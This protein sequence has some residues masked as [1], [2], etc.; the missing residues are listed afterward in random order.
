[1]K[2][3]KLFVVASMLTAF[4]SQAMAQTGERNPTLSPEETKSCYVF[5]ANQSSTF[6]QLTKHA[7]FVSVDAAKM[8]DLADDEKKFVAVWTR[9]NATKKPLPVSLCGMF[10]H[11]AED[12]NK[13]THDLVAKHSQIKSSKESL[14]ADGKKRATDNNKKTSSPVKK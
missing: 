5:L 12:I 14:N 2:Q 11:H 3:V 13:E 7:S 9:A 1:M 6:I 10:K 4:S 8:K